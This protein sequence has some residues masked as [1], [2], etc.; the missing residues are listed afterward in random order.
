MSFG[1]LNKEQINTKRIIKYEKLRLHDY[2]I[3]QEWDDGRSY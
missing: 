3:N 2:I 1:I